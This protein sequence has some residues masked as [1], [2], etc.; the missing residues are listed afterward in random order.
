[1]SDKKL[2][3]NLTIITGIQSRHNT[4]SIGTNKRKL[5]GCART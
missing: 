3:I 4:R 1:M 5:E 2:L